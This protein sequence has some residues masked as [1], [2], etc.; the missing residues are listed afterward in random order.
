M[1]DAA[2]L[3]AFDEQMRKNAPGDGT[4]AT[5]E[6]SGRVVR[7]LSPDP[8]G[9]SAIIWSDLDEASADGAIDEQV[10]FFAG[11]GQAFEWKHYAHD[12]PADLPA[13]LLAAGFEPGDEE[14]L[15]VA[16]VSRLDLGAALPPDL[17][18]ARV[19]DAAGVDLVVRAHEEVFGVEHGWLRQAMLAQLERAPDAMAA[20][21]ALAGEAPVCSGRVEFHPG[22]DFASLWGGGTLPAFRGRGVY[23]ALVAARA[24][25]A[26]E[27]GVRYLQVDA[28]PES[29]P[30]LER[31]GFRRLSST[32]PY[33]RAP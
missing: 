24:R 7:Y 5:V 19:R 27:R 10:R 28:S 14:A 21:V 4:G 31:L 32:T 3:A 20:F 6:R 12:R 1:N 23:R 18:L 26:A 17:R 15:M 22:A 30:I 8:A 11:R 9:W 2:L 33:L 25:L 13:R 29:R 16:E